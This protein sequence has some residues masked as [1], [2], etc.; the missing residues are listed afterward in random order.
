MRT[1]VDGLTPV[2]TALAGL[3]QRR[4]AD[5]TRGLVPGLLLPHPAPGWTAATALVT[6]DQLDELLDM[7]KQRWGAAPPA[8]AALA[9]RS[10][11]YWL[12]MPM[13][14]GWATARRVLLLDPDDV[15][16]RASVSH[17]RP[18]LTLGLRRVRLAVLPDDP[19]AERPD[20]TVVTSEAELLRRWRISLR[21]ANLDLLLAQLR[22]RVRLG[23]RTLLGSLASAVAYGA[24]RGYDAPPPAQV[25]IAQ[26]LLSALDVADLVELHPSPEGVTIRRRTCCLAFTLPDP[27]TCS[28]CCIPAGVTPSGQPPPG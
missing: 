22:A 5:A 13:V 11:T 17:R 24:A 12:A 18:L 21:E 3:R 9:W 25:E 27:R 20:V 28:G 16:I 4:G 19:L 7:A 10:Y 2:E 26:A 14:L 15:L 1:V 6:G 8:A 23:S